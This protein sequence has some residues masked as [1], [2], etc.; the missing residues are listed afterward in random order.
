MRWLRSASR[1][2]LAFPAIVLA[3]GAALFGPP[4]PDWVVT[5]IT[6]NRPLGLTITYDAATGEEL[7]RERFADRHPIDRVVGYGLA[8]HEGALFGAIN[9]VI[10]V[11]TALALVTMS[12]TA[13]LMWRRRKP[14]G[15]AGR[16]GAAGTAAQAA[17]RHHRH[18]GRWRCCCRCSP[19]RCCCCGCVDLLLPRVSPKAAAW[20]GLTP[21]FPTDLA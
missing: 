12:V 6:Q 20:L 19:P 7:S 2:P 3:P 9:Q 8:W 16:T 14:A 11:L 1:E 4:S 15:C 21:S 5:S 17:V 10:G 13:F 18:A